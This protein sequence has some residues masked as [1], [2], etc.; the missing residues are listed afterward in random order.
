MHATRRVLSVLALILGLAGVPAQAD[1]WTPLAKDQGVELAYQSV[2]NI[3]RLRFTNSNHQAVRVN[4]DLQVQLADGKTVGHHGDLPLAGGE[5]ET[6]AS[7][8]FHDATGP[9]E[10]RGISG[11]IH[12]KR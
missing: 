6:V 7:A 9:Q 1:D 10:V 11:V 12:A 5:T 3:A 2:G 4:W 8:P